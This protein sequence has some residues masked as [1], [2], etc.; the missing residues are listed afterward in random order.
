[1]EPSD[2]S[3]ANQRC[4]SRCRGAGEPEARH[5]DEIE[6]DVDESCGRPIP[7]DQ[8]RT[9]GSREGIQDTHQRHVSD[10]RQQQ[11]TSRRADRRVCIA[12]H[13]ANGNTKHLATQA[14]EP[15]PHYQ[16]ET[17]GY[18]YRLSN[19]L[20]AVGRAQLEELDTYVARR[21]EI[22]NSYRRYLGGI[23]GLDFMPEAPYGQSSRWLAVATLD[24]AVHP[25][26][27]EQV[28]L[29]LEDV[30][31]EARPVWKPLHM[32]P[33]FATSEATECPVAERLF[34]TGLCLPSGSAMSD[35]DVDRVCGTI[36]AT[37]RSS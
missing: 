1:M 20:A 19:L 33:A 36:K 14:R 21:R 13:T 9:P 16:H 30:N 22:F 26:G 4:G 28:R 10:N 8:S 7:S 31:V 25:A 12:S 2:E 5:E 15:F 11:Q 37:L 23:E 24:P 6:S 3:S 18:N 32:Q 29:A 27:P 35:A 17:V 34:A